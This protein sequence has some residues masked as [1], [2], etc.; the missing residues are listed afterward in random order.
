MP[1]T[2][3]PEGPLD[4]LSDTE[5]LAAA[6]SDPEAFCVVYD[7]HFEPIRRWFRSRVGDDA[8]ALDLTAETFAQALRSLHHFRDR[9]GGSAAPWLFGIA[10]NLW[11]KYE[12]R[13][14]VETKARRK[15]GI[16]LEYYEGEWDEIEER[17]VRERLRPNL[18]HALD[19]LPSDQRDALE[20]RVFD[21]LPYD[22]IAARLT[23]SEAAA[24]KRVMRALRTL[25]SRL[26]GANS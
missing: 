8:T 16:P 10:R 23:C 4:R 17:L 12:R 22:A 15:L 2:R 9:A 7:R 21:G 19:E 3:V 5:L 14:S 25:R 26:Q 13:R 24:R 1:R 6:S 11:L 18:A 20:L